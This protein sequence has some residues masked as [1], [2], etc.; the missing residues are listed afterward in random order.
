MGKGAPRPVYPLLQCGLVL[1]K[2]A[3]AL[4][5]AASKVF[6]AA[7]AALPILLVWDNFGVLHCVRAL[8]VQKSTEKGNFKRLTPKNA[9]VKAKLGP[10]ARSSSRGSLA[11][12]GAMEGQRHQATP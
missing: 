7:V 5:F 9:T 4:A 3:V 2:W 11:M 6:A 12:G 1:S 8:V 10:T